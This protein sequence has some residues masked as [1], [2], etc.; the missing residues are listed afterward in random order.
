M[1]LLRN[2][3]ADLVEKRL[4]PLVI[5]L[6][7]AL[8]A[9]P[10][11]LTRTA[12]P[13]GATPP[14][15]QTAKATAAQ[16]LALDTAGAAG[17]HRLKGR[18]PFKQLHVPK[19]ADDG[20]S[21]TAE[22]PSGAAPTTDASPGADPGDSGATRSSAYRIGLRFGTPG[23]L[24]R[25]H[26]LERLAPLPSRSDPFFVFLGVRS[27]GKT[28][29]FLVSSDAKGTGDGKC[30]PRPSVCSTVEMQV[31]DTEFFDLTRDGGSIVQ[32]QLDLLSITKLNG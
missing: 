26:D 2:V 31:G 19:P 6:V 14:A 12:E 27:D 16:A 7:A 29:V 15:S 32:Y 10:L 18:N 24:R 30:R 9:V 1:S 11:M 25:I 23:K 8:V 5:L 22:A 3:W 28:A 20:T 21:D 17:E 13:S 4:W